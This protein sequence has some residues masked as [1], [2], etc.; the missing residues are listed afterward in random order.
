[1]T[2]TTPTLAAYETLQMAYDFFNLHLFDGRLPTCLVLLERDRSALGH[3]WAE[4]FRHVSNGETLDEISINP[5]HAE[6]SN[7]HESYSSDN[8]ILMTMNVLGT[9][10]AYTFG[11]LRLSHFRAAFDWMRK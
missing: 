9:G 1:M 10:I 2:T 7:W 6:L 5:D 8:P 11:R 3:F 4:R